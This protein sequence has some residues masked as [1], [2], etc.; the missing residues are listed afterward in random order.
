MIK[1]FLKHWIYEICI[2][3]IFDALSRNFKDIS[4]INS[5]QIGDRFNQIM[6]QSGELSISYINPEVVEVSTL[7]FTIE[8]DR[9]EEETVDIDSGD[10]YVEKGDGYYIDIYRDDKT[11]K[12]I[13]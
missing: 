6:I 2:I 10:T 13:E 11:L 12:F 7:T 8:G 9:Y 5:I 1:T 3:Q 4:P